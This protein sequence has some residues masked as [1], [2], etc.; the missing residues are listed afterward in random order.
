[1]LRPF[2]VLRLT[3]LHELSDEEILDVLNHNRGI[4]WSK[5]T[6]EDM[7]EAPSLLVACTKLMDNYYVHF[8]MQDVINFENAFRSAFGY[9]P[10]RDANGEYECGQVRDAKVLWDMKTV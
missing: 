8:V 4:G 3:D 6:K 9:E 1:M 5:Y 10:E 2:K 7:Y